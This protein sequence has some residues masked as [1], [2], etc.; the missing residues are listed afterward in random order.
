MR[1]ELSGLLTSRVV[2]TWSMKRSRLAKSAGMNDAHR[3]HTGHSKMSISHVSRPGSVGASPVAGS[4]SAGSSVPNRFMHVMAAPVPATMPSTGAKSAKTVRNRWFTSTPWRN[5]ASVEMT[6][7]V[8][9]A[10]MHD[11]YAT[12]AE[13]CATKS[14]PTERMASKTKID[15]ESALYVSSVKRVKYITRFETLVSVMTRSRPAVHRPIHAY[16]G[17][18]ETW[19]T[20]EKE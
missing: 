5:P 17:R 2:M 3:S 8:A 19:S 13:P 10:T 18:K 15:A 14:V 7:Y 6:Q 11:K 16:I 20:S 4:A 9:S 12:S 1:I